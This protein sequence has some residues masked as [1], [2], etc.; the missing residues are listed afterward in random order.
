[1]HEGEIQRL[2]DKLDNVIKP[3]GKAKGVGESPEVRCEK[4]K[5]YKYVCLLWL[6]TVHLRTYGISFLP[7]LFETVQ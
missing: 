1:M 5:Y 4:V 3:G 2:L 6:I 7:V